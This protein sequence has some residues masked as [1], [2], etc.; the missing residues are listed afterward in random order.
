[1]SQN[2]LEFFPAAFPFQT[3][4]TRPAI[5]LLLDPPASSDRAPQST[6]RNRP[7]MFEFLERRQQI[8]ER[9]QRSRR[10]ARTTS[11]SRRR[12]ASIS[13]RTL[14]AVSPRRSPRGLALQSSSPAEQH[15]R[16]CIARVCC[17]LVETRA[18]S[19]ARNIFV[20]FRRWPKTLPDFAFSKAR[21]TAISRHHSRPGRSRSFSARQF[22]LIMQPRVLRSAPM[23]RGNSTASIQPDARPVPRDAEATPSGSRTD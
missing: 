23:P 8:R 15:I 12:A 6:K 13:S 7:E 22:H 18:Y 9:P 11:I 2:Q 19:P 1:M 14:P 17:S 10:H 20:R 21:W 5:Q 3:Q 4:Q 16:V